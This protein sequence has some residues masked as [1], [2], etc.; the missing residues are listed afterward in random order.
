[1]GRQGAE[2]VCG[3]IGAEAVVAAKAA[4]RRRR[5]DP[6]VCDPRTRRDGGAIGRYEIGKKHAALGSLG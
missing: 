3:A 6:G 1:M 5:L 2:G 4:D